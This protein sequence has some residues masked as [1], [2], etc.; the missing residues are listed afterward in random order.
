MNQSVIS[1]NPVILYGSNGMLGHVLCSRLVTSGF[2]VIPVFR[3]NTYIKYFSQLG[4][5]KSDMIFGEHVYHE[6]IEQQ[7]EQFRPRYIINCAGAIKQK[8]TPSTKTS[9]SWI[10][11]AF[12]HLIAKAADSIGCKVIQISTDCVFSGNEQY[13]TEEDQVSPIDDY[14]LS[15]FSG[16]LSGNHLTLRTSMIGYQLN[17]IEGL[18]EWF[19][20]NV[21][22]TI[23]GYTNAFFSGLTTS[24]L[25]DIIVS[26][27][28]QD[29]PITG[30]YHVAAN[31]ID[32]YSL[33]CNLRERLNVDIKIAPSSSFLCDR[34]LSPAK[35]QRDTNIRIP[36]WDEMIENIEG[37]LYRFNS[38]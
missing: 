28:K 25:S 18:L 38:L 5:S 11:A 36:Q 21:G 12:P 34:S 23:N 32:K 24:A 2:H 26:L 9:D 30:L 37:R 8:M 6:N 17:G 20:S 29:V 14:A 15:K 33:L 13:Y 7:I 27:I 31:R 19:L 10:N 1:K 22:E 4:I 3:N 16:E 35:F